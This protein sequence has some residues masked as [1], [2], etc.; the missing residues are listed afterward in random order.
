MMKGMKIE[1]S[2]KEFIPLSPPTS[3]SKDEDSQAER[4]R[5]IEEERN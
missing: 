5:G 4:E 1:K 3:H 2:D